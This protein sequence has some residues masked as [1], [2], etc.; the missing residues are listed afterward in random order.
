MRKGK[1]KSPGEMPRVGITP[2]RGALASGRSGESLLFLRERYPC[3]I[4]EAGGLP[5]A[6][7]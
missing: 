4:L 5:L 2:D 1:K 6:R 3:A 7:P